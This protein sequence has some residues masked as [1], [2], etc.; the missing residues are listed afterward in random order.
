MGQYNGNNKP[1]NY[2]EKQSYKFLSSEDVRQ[3]RMQRFNQNQISTSS[4][5]HEKQVVI[6]RTA[7]GQKRID[8]QKITRNNDSGHE[9]MKGGNN[10]NSNGANPGQESSKKQVRCKHFP[11]CLNKE[12]CPFVHPTEN[13]KYFPACTNGEKCLYLHPEIDCKFG[14]NCT[15]QNCAYKHPKGRVASK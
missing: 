2:P 7:D 4:I 3:K 10:N 11:H 6:T 13:C 1:Q 12:D 14:L 15:R 5:D 8:L 9:N